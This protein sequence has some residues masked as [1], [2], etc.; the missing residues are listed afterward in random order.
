MGE[1]EARGQGQERHTN[2]ANGLVGALVWN[3]V[4]LTMHK[5]ADLSD[6]QSERL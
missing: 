1:R 4:L 6:R 3:F 5:H 2:E